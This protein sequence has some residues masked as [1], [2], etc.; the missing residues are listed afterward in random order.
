MCLCEMLAVVSDRWGRIIKSVS[1]RGQR[2]DRNPPSLCDE[3]RRRQTW[4][5]DAPVSFHDYSAR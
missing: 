1:R 2:G 3:E 4:E 5:Q